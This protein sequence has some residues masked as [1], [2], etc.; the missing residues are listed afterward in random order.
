MEKI[1]ESTVVQGS[2]KVDRVHGLR[3]RN[4]PPPS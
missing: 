1:M 4:G 3:L 2:I